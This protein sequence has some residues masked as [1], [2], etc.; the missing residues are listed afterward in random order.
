MAGRP[1]PSSWVAL[2]VEEQI[3]EGE[4]HIPAHGQG[5]RV[6]AE[7]PDAGP[8][9]PVVQGR[10]PR[11]VTELEGL[12]EQ[13]F[14]GASS[15]PTTGE[16]TRRKPRWTPSIE[17]Q[18]EDEEAD[19]GPSPQS[20]ARPGR[21]GCSGGTGHDR[22]SGTGVRWSSA[23]RRAPPAVRPPRARATSP[24]PDV[25]GVAERVPEQVE[26]HHRDEDRQARH[27]GH[28]PV[29]GKEGAPARHHGPPVRR[30]LLGA[31]ARGR[32]ARSRAGSRR[33][34]R[35]SPSRR[36]A[37]RRSAGSRR[38]EDHPVVLPEGAR[39]LDVGLLAPREDLPVDG[40]V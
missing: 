9:E 18:Q 31:H 19:A 35:A 15:M 14:A 16:S 10:L 17:A 24:L 13:S 22:H 4:R 30:G 25:E 6:G 8:D 37:T 11:K 38:P 5:D 20:A 33:T 3:D 23:G 36:W 32:R 1:R 7:E 21:S 2:E 39:R 34:R 29:D 26:P 28:P 40:A 12:T 27:G